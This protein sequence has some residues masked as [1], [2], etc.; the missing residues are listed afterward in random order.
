M[1]TGRNSDR[2]RAVQ[3]PAV[4]DLGATAGLWRELTAMSGQ[5]LRI[6]ASGVERI[7][8][9]CLQI[10]IAAEAKWAKDGLMFVVDNPSPAY[11]DGVRLMTG[12][13]PKTSELSA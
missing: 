5:P 9:L 11:I 12:A 6:D 7:G 4:L 1:T 3:L 8:G 2:E 10:L 13:L